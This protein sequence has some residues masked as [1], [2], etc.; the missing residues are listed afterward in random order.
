MLPRP[1][2]ISPATSSILSQLAARKPES[3]RIEPDEDLN[4]NDNDLLP[5]EAFCDPADLKAIEEALREIDPSQYDADHDGDIFDPNGF[6]FGDARAAVKPVGQKVVKKVV[7]AA[8]QVNERL[9]EPADGYAARLLVAVNLPYRDPGPGTVNWHRENR[10][11]SLDITTGFRRGE[12][13]G[14]PYGKYPRL[15]MMHLVTEAVRTKEPVINLGPTLGDYLA[16][17]GVQRGGNQI[18]ALREQ[19]RR[20]FSAQFSWSLEA[21]N[22]WAFEDVK[23][24]KKAALWWDPKNPDQPGLWESSVT[25]NDDF[26]KEI[27]TRPVPW[28]EDA[29]AAVSS[30]ALGLD[31][32]LFLSWRT[33]RSEE[34]SPIPQSGIGI[35]WQQLHDQMGG[36]YADLREF[37]RDAKAQLVRIKAVWPGLK[38]ETPRGRLVLHKSTPLVAPR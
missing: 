34:A 24:V 12:P 22:G 36:Q 30:S 32:L 6:L 8:S 5:P 19:M 25:L 35:S 7:E 33:Y 29:L 16:K 15:I 13:V 21:E 9:R 4:M 38:F 20:L 26:F 37:T 23:P 31:L 11:I 2:A 1:A 18:A 14:L 10:G 28:R 3:R 17:I 27:C